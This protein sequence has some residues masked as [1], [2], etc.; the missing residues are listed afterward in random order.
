MRTWF[1]IWDW[2]PEKKLE[3]LLRPQTLNSPAFRQKTLR[4]GTRWTL[5]EGWLCLLRAVQSPH[6]PLFLY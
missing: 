3:A 1:P 4:L 6:E 5:T 2:L